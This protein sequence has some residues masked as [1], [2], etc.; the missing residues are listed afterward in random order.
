M[1]PANELQFVLHRVKR[2]NR[3]KRITL[4]VY[5]DPHYISLTTKIPPQMHHYHDIHHF[6]LHDR[7]TTPAPHLQ[8]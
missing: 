1:K 3:I 7:L 8:T 2:M 6:Q 4:L 5:V